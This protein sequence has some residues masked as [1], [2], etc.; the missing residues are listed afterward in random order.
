MRELRIVRG[1]PAPQGDDVADVQFDLVRR[2]LL[3]REGPARDE[4]SERVYGAETAEAVR[5]FQTQRGLRVDGVVGPVTLR[6]LLRDDIPLQSRLPAPNYRDADIFGAEVLHVAYAE[7]SKVQP[8]GTVG[9]VESPWGSNRGPDVDRYLQWFDPP[10]PHDAPPYPGSSQFLQDPHDRARGCPW[11]ALFCGAVCQ[12]AADRLAVPNP[13][14]PWG[15]LSSVDEWHGA[16]VRARALVGLDQLRPGDLGLLGDDSPRFY[17]HIVLITDLD[18]SRGTYQTIEGNCDNAVRMRERRIE[19]L[20][21]GIR[22]PQ[23][24]ALEVAGLAY[25]PELMELPPQEGGPQE[26][27]GICAESPNAGSPPPDPD[28][29]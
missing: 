12:W 7:F 20:L 9:V 26:P 27:T 28:A 4:L 2:G 8:D 16:A 11:C 3:R 5:H 13:V 22:L 17:R 19:D 21:E 6:E 14:R 23:P 29:L 18:R 24:P 10:R 15:L 1:Q 25:S